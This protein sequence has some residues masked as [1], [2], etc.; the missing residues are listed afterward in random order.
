MMKT[1]TSVWM[2]ALLLAGIGSELPAA[3]E[4]TVEQA[5]GNWSTDTQQSIESAGTEVLQ[6]LMQEAIQMQQPQLRMRIRLSD[7][8]PLELREQSDRNAAGNVPVSGKLPQGKIPLPT[9][10]LG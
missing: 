2:V 3:D 9:G 6:Q 1:Y 8:M 7:E 4:Q 5:L 10:E